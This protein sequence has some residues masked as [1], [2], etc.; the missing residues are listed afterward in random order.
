MKN[1]FLILTSTI[2]FSCVSPRVVEDMKVRMQRMEVDNTSLKTQNEQLSVKSKEMELQIEKL[3]KQLSGL[4]HDTTVMSRSLRVTTSNYD[5]LS[6]T[7]EELLEKNRELLAGS[8]SQ[9]GQLMQQLQKTE[10]DLQKREDRLKEIERE[11]NEKKASLEEMTVQLQARETTLKELQTI[12]D[13]K[14]KQVTALREK[15]S[16]ALLGFENKGL[17]VT[18]K[19]GKVFVS[20]EEQLL[21]KSGSYTVDQ[22]GLEALKKLAKVL[23]TQKEISVLIEGH[24][25]N[26]SYIPS[27][28]IKDN[29]DLSV[30]RATSVVKI[31]QANGVAI[32]PKQL[33]AAGRGE[34]MPV[35]PANTPEARQKNRRIEIILTPRLDE[36]FQII[37]K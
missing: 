5:K 23:E 34:Y 30:M 4:S 19:E 13:E 21:F 1:T 29:W 8:K 28:N 24:T 33:T 25:D 37:N 6:Q 11:M 32:D 27:G 10:E 35:D 20:L 22:K 16:Q 2:L 3:N 26:V 9:T 14:D 17:T 18:Q 12:L 7:Y 15:V 31:L 36:L